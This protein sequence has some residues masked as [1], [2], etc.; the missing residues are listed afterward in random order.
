MKT[1]RL[2]F[3]L[4]VMGSIFVM[5]QGMTLA[6][7]DSVP[8]EFRICVGDYA[9]CAASTCMRDGKKIAVNNTTTLF[10]EAQCTCPIFSGASIADVVGGNMKGSCQPPPDNGIWSS[11]SPKAHI[12][13]AI[14]DWKKHGPQA[15]SPGYVCPATV[16]NNFQFTNCFS[17][18]CVRAGEING[19]RVATCFCPIQESLDAQP[20][21]LGTPFGTQAGQ[22]QQSFCSQYPVGAPFQFDDISPGQCIEI[23]AGGVDV[24]FPGGGRD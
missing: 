9:L 2:L 18:A 4:L 12:P 19:V 11:Y 14:N 8:H 22:C 15:A 5:S 17:F 10:D 16:A 23:P 21:P 1:S 13:Q 7:T 24:E 6:Q 3:S 20:V